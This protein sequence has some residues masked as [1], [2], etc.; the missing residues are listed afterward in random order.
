MN[1]VVH[2]EDFYDMLQ[3][4]SYFCDLKVLVTQ[5]NAGYSNPDDCSVRLF[6]CFVV[7]LFCFEVRK[8]NI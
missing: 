5:V 2:S 1:S 8:N 4:V 6:Y 3:F 7:L